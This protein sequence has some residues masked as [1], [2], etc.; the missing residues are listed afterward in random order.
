MKNTIKRLLLTLGILAPGALMAQDATI[1]TD[2]AIY[3]MAGFVLVVAVLVLVVAVIVLQVLKTIVRQEDEKKAA[4]QGIEL[5]EPVSF[6]SRFMRKASDAVPIEEEETVLLDHNY[7]G[8]QELDN[9][10][11]PWWKWLFYMTI[12][13]GVVYLFVYH[14]TDTLPLQQEEYDN[15]IAEAEALKAMRLKDSPKLAIDESTVQYVEDAAALA[16]GKQVYDNNCS[17]CHRSDGGGSIGPNL[18]DEYWLHGGS[19]QDIFTT[20]KVGVPAKG[21]ISW[22]PLLSPEQMQNVASYVMSMVGT[23]P[24]N[25]KAPQGEVYRA[26]EPTEE[27]LPDSV[28]TVAIR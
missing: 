10:L 28:Q 2:T 25:P 7:D 14:V 21:M 20:I 27:A 26:G 16:S 19:I 8:I 23:N 12:A 13:F 9:H 5:P 24:P 11:P 6:W 22:E 4:V 1:S 18:T 17:Q 3:F 15:Q